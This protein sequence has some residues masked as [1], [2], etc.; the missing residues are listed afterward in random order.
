VRRLGRIIGTQDQ[1][2]AESAEPLVLSGLFGFVDEASF[3]HWQEINSETIVDLALSRSTIAALEDD[4]RDAKIEEVRAFY[5]EY[6]RGMDGMQLPYVARC[7][8]AVVNDRPELHSTEEDETPSE[9]PRTDGP[10]DDM[11]LIDFR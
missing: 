8:Q 6:G 5:A 4:A 9:E 2:A 11:L 1:L 10:D 3:P 7:Y